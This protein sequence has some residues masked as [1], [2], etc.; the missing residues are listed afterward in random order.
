MLKL[1]LD[2]NLLN[3]STPVRLDHSR[4]DLRRDYLLRPSRYSKFDDTDVKEPLNLDKKF[5][6][7]TIKDSIV[8]DLKL[9]CRSFYRNYR[10]L[11]VWP[12]IYC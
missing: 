3:L 5:A 7:L 12:L 1:N 6:E 9:N 2:K 10:Y 11:Y 8:R 4:S